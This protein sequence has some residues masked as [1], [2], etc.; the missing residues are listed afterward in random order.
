[1][2]D[3]VVVLGAGFGGLNTAIRIAR[4]GHEVKIIDSSRYHE[5]TPGLIDVYRDRVSEDRLKLDI[6]SF[7]QGISVEFSREHVDGIYPERNV[8]E[9]GGRRHEYDQ[10][11][12][13]LGSEP[14]PH[15]VDIRDAGIPY[16]L[17][18]TKA[19]VEDLEEGDSV[20]V[21]GGGY[22][23]VEIATELGC[24]GIDVS[25]VERST[26]PLPDSNE[27][28]SKLA[29][30]YLNRKE[31]NF[32]GGKEVVG[33]SGREVSFQDGTTMEA[34]TV[35]WAA[36]IRTPKVVRESFGVGEKGIPVNAGLASEE[37]PNVFAVGDCAKNGCAK[38]A[39]NAMREAATVAENIDRSEDQ[40]LARFNK[41]TY[42]VVISLG[43]TGIFTKGEFAYRHPL[44]RRLKD[45]IRM[46][47]WYLLRKLKWKNRFS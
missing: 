32:R 39:R 18:R 13:A 43:D 7:L 19:I 12:L 31:I 9:T 30:D 6:E 22:V 36:G 45:I 46:R 5:F 21:V 1:M 15:G 17:E 24:R 16:S 44:V 20:A 26:R 2:D 4:R 29:L 28:S 10:L 25:V 41:K 8:V 27:R 3:K 47:Y 14:H 33:V 35:L 37:Y 11:V 38:T 23:G 42:P 34:D 40:E